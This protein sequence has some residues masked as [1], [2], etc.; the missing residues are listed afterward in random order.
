MILSL[1]Q[2]QAVENGEPVALN[3]AGTECVLVR[4]DI[5]LSLDSDYDAGPWTAEEMNL[6][7]VEAEEMI[8]RRVRET[9]T[10]DLSAFN[11]HEIPHY[12]SVSGAGLAVVSPMASRLRCA[13]PHKCF[14]GQPAAPAASR[15][16]TTS[17]R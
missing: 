14:N 4:K 11:V 9:G 6:L 16:T 3:V 2:Q 5:Y 15:L 1:A 10:D 8:S 17:L 12:T 13:Y 7:A